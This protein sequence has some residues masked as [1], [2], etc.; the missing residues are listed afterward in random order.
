MT[1]KIDRKDFLNIFFQPFQ[2][3]KEVRI[4]P[5]YNSR[6]ELFEK[7]CTSCAGVCSSVCEEQILH[8]GEDGLPYIDFDKGICTFCGSCAE[9]CEKNVLESNGPATIP[10]N[11]NL[12]PI[13]CVAWNNTMCTSCKDSCTIDAIKMEGIFR[14][15]IDKNICTNCNACIKVCPTN[16]IEINE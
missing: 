15:Q 7:H 14:P 9:Y 4:R 6:T 8:I 11:I 10:A 1:K 5:P 13:K 3:K 16:S 12:D 2:E